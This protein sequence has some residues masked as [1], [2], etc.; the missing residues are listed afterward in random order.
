MEQVN[1]LINE[2]EHDVKYQATVKTLLTQLNQAKQRQNI[3]QYKHLYRQLLNKD[4]DIY[5]V[6]Y[7][8][9]RLFPP[10]RNTDNDAEFWFDY[11]GE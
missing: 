2:L 5:T 4:V 11:K 9:S 1:K 8:S 6:A 10:D 3:Q 7:S